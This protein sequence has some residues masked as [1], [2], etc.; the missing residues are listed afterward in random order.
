MLTNTKKKK[1]ISNLKGYVK[2][3]INKNLEN[4]DESSTRLMI[5]SFLT[6]VLGYKAI[7]E[8]K[9][10]YMIKGT[11]ADYVVQMKGKQHFLVEVKASSLELSEKHLHQAVNYG[12]NEGIEWVLLTNGRKFELYKVIF[13]KPLTERKVFSIDIGDLAQIKNIAESIQYLHRDAVV[14][15]G[16]SVLWNKYNALEPMTISGLLVSGPVIKFVRRELKKKYKHN[17]S[18]T[19]ISEAIRKVI[20]EE[21]AID[22]V[23][24]AKIHKKK[25][26]IQTGLLDAPLEEVIATAVV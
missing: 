4:L 9:T 10:E 21:V 8:V 18:E 6:E 11:Y 26:K 7:E 17:F 19:D 2:K 13:D 15:K 24:T 22:N 16:L 25:K 20:A 3:Y 23:K 5:N 1:L 12:A 14:G